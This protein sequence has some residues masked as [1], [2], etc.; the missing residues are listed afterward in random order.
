MREE[1]TQSENVEKNSYSGVILEDL[2]SQS[3]SIMENIGIYWQVLR[4]FLLYYAA[5]W[6]EPLNQL[7]I[8]NYKK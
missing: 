4:Y 5:L 7:T 2:T 6:I 1:N 8:N 3:I